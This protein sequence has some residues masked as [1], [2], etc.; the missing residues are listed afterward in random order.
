MGTCR[1][2]GSALKSNQGTRR[3]SGGCS[4]GPADLQRERCDLDRVDEMRMTEQTL[5][6]VGGPQAMLDFLARIVIGLT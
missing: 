5:A 4:H 6:H 2:R 1:L 3:V